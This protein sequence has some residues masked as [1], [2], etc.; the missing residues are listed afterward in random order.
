MGMFDSYMIFKNFNC[1]VC[2]TKFDKDKYDFQCKEL[3]CALGV[4]RLGNII[5]PSRRYIWFYSGCQGQHDKTDYT[6]P[7]DQKNGYPVYPTI[8][9]ICKRGRFWCQVFLD[10]EGK[11]IK[12]RVIMEVREEDKERF[13]YEEQLK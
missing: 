13:I 3:D 4:Y 5:D 10:E 9:G 11:A 2:G 1:P 12:E 6:K 7:P 8:K